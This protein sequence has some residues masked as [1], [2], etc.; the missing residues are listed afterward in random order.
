VLEFALDLMKKAL[1]HAN[2]KTVMLIEFMRLH[3]EKGGICA[4]RD[5]DHREQ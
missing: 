2:K 4:H 5:L 3:P 1:S